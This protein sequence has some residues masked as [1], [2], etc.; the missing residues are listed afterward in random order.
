MDV[1]SES[2]VACLNACRSQLDAWNK[3]EFGHVGRMIAELQKHLEWLELQP[4]SPSTIQDMRRTRIE[5]SC[6]HEKEDT[7]WHQRSRI[8]WFQSG[9]RNTGFFH[10]KASSRQKKNQMEGLVDA[11]GVWQEDE[12]IIGGIVLD[13]YTDLFTSNNPTGFDEILE[14]VQPRVTSSMNQKLTMEFTADEVNVALKQMYPLK[15][16]RLDGMP[17]LFFQHFWPK[18]GDV[19]TRTILDFLNL[20]LTPPNFNETDIV[21]IPK[22]KE[23]KMVIDYRPISLSN[24]VF[25]IASKA[26][27]N[28]MK[29]ILHSIISDTQSAFMHGRLI[30]DNVLV[31]FEA[32][33]HINRRKGGK[34]VI[35]L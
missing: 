29:K 9:D 33:H 7:M 22:V 2:M 25:K 18:I 27:A 34:M 14:A 1:W 6:W 35:W 11:Q 30:T 31:A 16:P 19:V 28:R 3:V 26:I 32:M 15:A 4:S 20:G 17:H 5:L 23:P 12:E 13:Y 21:L 8:N 24:V 10:A